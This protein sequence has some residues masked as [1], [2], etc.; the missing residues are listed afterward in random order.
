MGLML[1]EWTYVKMNVPYQG[2]EQRSELN[3]NPIKNL[4][5]MIH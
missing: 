2:N 1:K 5:P 3:E 4:K